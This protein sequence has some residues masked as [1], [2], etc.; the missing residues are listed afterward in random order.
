[1]KEFYGKEQNQKQIIINK[2]FPPPPTSTTNKTQ[3]TTRTQASLMAASTVLNVQRG[4]GLSKFAKQS[5][6]K[7]EV[8]NVSE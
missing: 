1:M 8:K 3:A 4:F 7:T 6:G 5:K 2:I